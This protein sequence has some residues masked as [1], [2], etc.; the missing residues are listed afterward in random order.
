MSR[1]KLCTVLAICLYKVLT[2]VLCLTSNSCSRFCCKKQNTSI[3]WCQPRFTNLKRSFCLFFLTYRQI[4]QHIFF[5]H[6]LWRLLRFK[7]KVLIR[8]SKKYLSGSI[9]VLCG[10]SFIIRYVFFAKAKTYNRSMF[11]SSFSKRSSGSLSLLLCFG[12]FD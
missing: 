7:I 1:N 6:H 9:I 2:S 11:L 10:N 3:Y 8:R 5:I 4:Q 12:F